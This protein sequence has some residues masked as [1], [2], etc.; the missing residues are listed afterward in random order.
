VATALAENAPITV[1]NHPS[2]EHGFDNQ[3]D[4]ERSREIILGAL[5]FMKAHLARVSSD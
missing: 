1:V 5:E 3:N 4:D 2:G